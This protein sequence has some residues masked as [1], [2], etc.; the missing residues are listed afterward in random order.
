MIGLRGQFVAGPA[1]PPPHPAASAS[2]VML[3]VADLDVCFLDASWR[4]DVS[5]YGCS[6]YVYSTYCLANYSRTSNAAA[7]IRYNVSAEIYFDP[8]STVFTGVHLCL[9]QVVIL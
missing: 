1:P 6:L 8:F 5:I 3:I 9:L 7:Y 4:Y 2:L